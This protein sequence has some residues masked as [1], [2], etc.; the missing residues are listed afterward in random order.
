LH[1]ACR[2]NQFKDEKFCVTQPF[3]P[4]FIVTVKP[5][6]RLA[7]LVIAAHGLAI[8]AGQANALPILYKGLLLIVLVAHL[9]YAVKR[10]NHTLPSL[11]Y[12]DASGWQ[13][14]G[15]SEFE[16]AVILKSTV[17][18]PFA[19]WLHTSGRAKAGLFAGNKN[20]IL[21]AR[22]ALEEDDYRRLIVKLKTTVVE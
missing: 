3:E 2:L 12:A 4:P 9:Y 6:R 1:F 11:K 13:I 10:L 14:A 22:D 15:D 18:T 16:S 5:S 20:T 7:R 19:I 21:I 8:A 17:V